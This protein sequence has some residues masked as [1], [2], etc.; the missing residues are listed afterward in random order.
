MIKLEADLPIRV[1]ESF[2]GRRGIKQ[3]D[4]SYQSLSWRERWW[5][6][7]VFW[8]NTFIIAVFK[9]DQW[10]QQTSRKIE[11]RR[12]RFNA[13][14][15]KVGCNGR[16]D[17]YRRRPWVIWNVRMRSKRWTQW[18]LLYRSCCSRNLVFNLLLLAIELLN[19]MIGVIDEGLVLTPIVFVCVLNVC[20]HCRYGGSEFSQKAV[21]VLIPDQLWWLQFV[22]QSSFKVCVFCL[23]Q[24]AEFVEFTMLLII[25]S[26][27]TGTAKHLSYNLFQSSEQGLNSFTNTVVQYIIDQIDQVELMNKLTY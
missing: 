4:S 8:I 24:T 12:L 21:L 3:I 11:I 18:R 22:K 7:N 27:Q 13:F 16:W 23:P 15:W 17:W 19:L 25:S 20:G 10:D 1:S 6:S 5:K 2:V 14:C 26:S 9:F